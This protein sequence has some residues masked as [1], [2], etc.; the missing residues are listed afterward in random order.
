M[1]LF[2]EFLDK[3]SGIFKA[4]LAVILIAVPVV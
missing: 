1:I 2:I 3:F 4:I